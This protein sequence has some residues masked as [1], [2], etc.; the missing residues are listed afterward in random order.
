MAM[1]SY[2]TE[3]ERRLAE[4][5]RTS[6]YR[7][8]N[9]AKA[10]IVAWD[11]V[12]AADVK[13]FW[14]QG[15]LVIDHMYAPEEVRRFIEAIQDIMFERVRGPHIQFTKPRDRLITDEEREL[16]IRK[17]DRFVQ[18]DQRLR[19]AAHHDGLF[20][21]LRRLFDDEPKLVQDQ[22]ILKPPSGGA[23]KPW[24][25]DMAYGN[26]TYKKPV[27]GVWA[28]LDPATVENGCMHVI[29]R[30]H[31]DGPA[32]HYAIR[33]WQICDANV[34]VHK[35]VVVPLPP[36]G[37]LIFHGMLHH[38]TPPNFSMERRRAVQFHYAPESAVKMA[39]DEYKRWFTNEMTNAEC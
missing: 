14:E 9:P 22:A 11:R 7:Y 23:E 25:Q 27:I 5:V 13:R 17:V 2:E 38:G 32:P 18:Y 12:A 3:E 37:A 28:A 19:D 29:P 10:R 35:D 6:M 24:H 34:Q 21:V 31:M 30:S 8:D 36:G 4:Q 26:L 1:V 16:A 20:A 15:F 33:D 39:P